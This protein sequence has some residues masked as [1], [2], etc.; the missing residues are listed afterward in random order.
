Y[1]EK[2]GTFTNSSGRVQL[3]RKAGDPPGDAREDWETILQIYQ[4][5]SGER[6]PFTSASEIFLKISEEVPGYRDMTYFNLGS[7]GRPKAQ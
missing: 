2:N 1:I 3:F 4:K 6:L 7:M 5:I